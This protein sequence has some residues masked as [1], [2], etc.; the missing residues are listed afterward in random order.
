MQYGLL[1]SKIIISGSAC[2]CVDCLLLV[3]HVLWCLSHFI[4]MY[5][6]H[7]HFLGLFSETSLPA[8]FLIH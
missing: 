1:E 5:S 2:W 3:V 4:N 6:E 8:I 7:Q